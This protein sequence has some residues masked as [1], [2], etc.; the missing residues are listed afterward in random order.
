[1]AEEEG[2]SLDGNCFDARIEKR[3][4]RGAQFCPPRRDGMN[5]H[6][7]QKNLCRHLKRQGVRHLHRRSCKM[8]ETTPRLDHLQYALPKRMWPTMMKQGDEHVFGSEDVRMDYL[9]VQGA[10]MQ[11]QKM[12]SAEHYRRLFGKSSRRYGGKGQSTK[13]VLHYYRN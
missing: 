1:M 5:R 4:K 12:G 2:L 10:M 7:S 6:P 11:S 8:T 9:A 3:G 13:A